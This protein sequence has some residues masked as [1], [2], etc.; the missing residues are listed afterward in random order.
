MT[1]TRKSIKHRKDILLLHFL[2]CYIFPDGSV[3]CGG[4]GGVVYM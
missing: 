3:G 4:G 1:T 2:F